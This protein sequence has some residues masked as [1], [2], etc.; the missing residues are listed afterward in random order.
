MKILSLSGFVPE[1]ICDTVR[2][3][4]Y[5][6]DRNLSHYCGYASDY[7]S[8][9]LKDDSIDGAVFPKSCDSTRIIASYLK[10]CGKFFYQMPVP[11]SRSEE[12][13]GYLAHS[14]RRYR[15]AL[16]AYYGISINDVTERAELVNLRNEKI[17]KLYEDISQIPY[18]RYLDRMHALLTQSLREQSF[19]DDD[20]GH[21]DQTGGRKTFL[22]GSYLANAKI[23][24]MIEA[25]GFRVVGDNLPESGRLAHTPPVDLEDDIYH[26]IARSL[27]SNRVSPTQND[28]R[29]LIEKDMEEMEQKDASCVIFVT[30]QYCEPYD[31]LYTLYR[32]RLDE[33]G[34]PVLH[35]KVS[36]TEDDRKVA[37]A[38]EA[39]A[40]TL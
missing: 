17:R 12:A 8:Q 10:D 2:F 28:F 15:E 4:Q 34:I 37:L 19:C 36:D 38:V 21:R 5:R 29:S 22:V 1:Q 26:G 27:L 9:V 20:F 40:D 7:I 3:T 13:A 32:K 33:K 23:A 39:F 31:F 24:E 25:A 30:Q 11:S 16:E 14:I 35:L 6:G 18:G